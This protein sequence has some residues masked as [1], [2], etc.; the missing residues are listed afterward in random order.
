MVINVGFDDDT[1]VKFFEK[2]QTEELRPDVSSPKQQTEDETRPP[3]KK[4]QNISLYKANKKH[5]TVLYN[6]ADIRFVGGEI[7]LFFSLIL[8]KIYRAMPPL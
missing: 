4:N 7:F 8:V 6:V 2:F 3:R 5:F 1:K